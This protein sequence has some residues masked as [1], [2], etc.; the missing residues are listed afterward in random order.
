MKIAVFSDRKRVEKYLPFCN[1]ADQAELLFLERDCTDEEAIIKAGDAEYIF[2]DAIKEVSE[3][4]I[5]HMPNLK[6]IHSEGVGFNRID[7]EAARKCRVFVCNNKGANAGAVAEQTILL[8]LG[9]L[10]DVL[11]GDKQVRLGNQIQTKERMMFEGITELADCKVGLIGFGD[12]ARETAKRLM[13]FQA[14]IYY[15]SRTRA[16]VEIEE[17]YQVRYLE[18]EELLSKCDIVSLHMPVTPT[19]I[20]M[21]DEA[22]IDKM[23]KGA[24]LI[25]TA[26]GELVDQEALKEALS[27]GKIGGA[28]LD[29][30]S[31]EPVMLDNPLLLLPEDKQ[32]KLLLSPHIGGTTDGAFRK[33]HQG[34]WNNIFRVMQGGRPENIVNGL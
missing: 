19:T 12:I 27:C 7:V 6:L 3:F 8:M 30:L 24:I 21:V 32:Y 29:T 28:G 10:R 18:L 13:A 25:N 31:P 14:Q 2:A 23:K 1:V 26:R 20:E 9:L 34:V 16:S 11:N 5:T 22:F 4:L 15:Y 17:A 33:M